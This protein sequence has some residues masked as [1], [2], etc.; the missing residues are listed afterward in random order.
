M[1]KDASAGDGGAGAVKKKIAAASSSNMKP[2]KMR[3]QSLADVGHP[4][5]D[6]ETIMGDML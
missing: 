4:K 3:W 2:P 5:P 6:K 1:G